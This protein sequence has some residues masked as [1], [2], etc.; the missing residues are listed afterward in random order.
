MAT[1]SWNALIWLSQECNQ[2]V[3]DKFFTVVVDGITKIYCETDYFKRLDLICAKCGLALRGPYINALGRK[4]HMEHFTCSVCPTTFRQNDSYYERDGQVFCGHHYSIFH[5]SKCGGCN[6]AVL[7]NF[8]EINKDQVSKQWHPPCY[9]IYKLWS[10]QLSSPD[11]NAQQES[12]RDPEVEF[13]KQRAMVELAEQILQVLSAF[14]ESAAACISDMLLHFSD[15][16]N[17]QCALQ[18]ASFIQHVDVLFST[19]D[20]INRRLLVLG[21]TSPLQQTK[22]PKQLIKRIFYFFTNLSGRDT[23]IK[24]RAT[25]G[26]IQQVTNL[27]HTLKKVIRTA[28]AGSLRLEQVYNDKEAV[29][30]FLSDLSSIHTKQKERPMRF[31][32]NNADAPCIVCQQPFDDESIRLGDLLW[33][34]SCFQCVECGRNLAIEPAL[35]GCHPTTFAVYCQAHKPIDALTGAERISRFQRSALETCYGAHGVACAYGSKLKKNSCFLSLKRKDIEI[36][37]AVMM[38]TESLLEIVD[39]PRSSVWSKMVGAIKPPRRRQKGTFGVNLEDLVEVAGVDSQLG[40]GTGTVRIPLLMDHCIRTLQMKG[41]IHC[42]TTRRHLMILPHP[43]KIESLTQW[44]VDVKHIDLDTEGIF[45]KNGNIRR[46]KEVC[47]RINKDPRDVDL[48]DDNPIQI[49]AL[50]KKFLRDMPDP[51]LTFKLKDLFM[52]TQ[53][54]E[55]D[56]DRLLALRLTCCLLPKPNLDLLSVLCR[57]LLEVASHSGPDGQTG[58]KMHIENIATVIA[59]NV[60]YS[61]AGLSPEESVYSVRV[62]SM[63]LE[64]LSEVFKVPPIILQGLNEDGVEFIPTSKYELRRKHEDIWSKM[65]FRTGNCLNSHVQTCPYIIQREVDLAD[66]IIRHNHA[67]R[68]E[69]DDLVNGT[70]DA[71]TRLTADDQFAKSRR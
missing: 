14:E 15:E 47:E 48:S 60:L 24:Q 70:V 52:A 43:R 41:L 7:K 18:A 12:I 36:K 67:P 10:A 53:K 42:V 3:A 71:S 38:K 21:D 5:A 65:L 34:L 13:Q 63:L 35:A 19:I 30:R 20:N 1:L 23:T 62:L 22:E 32:P 57:F 46:L 58:N 49:A 44:L 2:V 51:L 64:N 66:Q 4:Y 26:L 37:T 31:Y 33:H 54:L 61:K 39:A 40:I 28:F 68:R 27:A 9:M 17:L 56:A 11:V 8:V 50:M 6:T 55:T 69:F 16:N 45:R 29:A 25:P 59:P